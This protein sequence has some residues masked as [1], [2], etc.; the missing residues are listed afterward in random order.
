MVEG[1]RAGA[2]VFVLGLEGGKG[3]QS[4]AMDCTGLAE[5]QK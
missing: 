3:R 5:P 2:D 1:S 4:A